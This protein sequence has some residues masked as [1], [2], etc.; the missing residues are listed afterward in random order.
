MLVGERG[1]LWMGGELL[2]HVRQAIAHLRNDR[3]VSKRMANSRLILHHDHAATLVPTTRTITTTILPRSY[4]LEQLHNL[5]RP[6]NTYD[7]YHDPTAIL[8]A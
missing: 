5:Q 8:P 4:L 2:Q 6:C 3:Q 7:Y 1:E